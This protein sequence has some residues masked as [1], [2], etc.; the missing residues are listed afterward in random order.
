MWGMRARVWI[1]ALVLVGLLAA[2]LASAA[3]ARPVALKL[4]VIGSGTVRVTGSHPFTCTAAWCKHTFQ[5]ARGKRITVKASPQTG[6][7]LT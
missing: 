1:A 6:W 7:K 4:T 5:V 3:T 2:S